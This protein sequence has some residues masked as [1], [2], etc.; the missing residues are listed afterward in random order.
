[1]HDKDRE[2]VEGMLEAYRHGFFPM[3]E[4]ARK[5]RP[6]PIRWFN[7]DP[8]TVIPLEPPGAEGGGFHVPRSLRRAVRQGRFTITTDTCFEAVMRGCASP[9]RGEPDSWIDERI[10]GAYGALH[11]AGRAHSIEAWLKEQ[12]GAREG[13]ETS[14]GGRLVGGLYGVHIGG[15]FFAESKFSRPVDGGTNASK[16]C[17]VHLVGHLRRRGF[18]L[19]DVQL[20][21][22]HLQQFGIAELAR[23]E[24]MRRLGAAVAAACAWTPFEPEKT[25]ET[26]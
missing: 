3:A 25:R 14:A 24:Y 13:Q 23:E 20:T 15:A 4:P 2:L 7:P 12:T 9:R 6:G 26:A 1:M 16:I 18:T 22:P 11:R 5:G 8:R 10:I 17:L 19:L 21:N